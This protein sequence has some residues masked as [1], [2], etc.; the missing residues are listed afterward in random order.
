MAKRI[1]K[2]TITGRLGVNFIEQ[3]VLKMGFAWNPS[4]VDAGI[5]GYIE[6]RDQATDEAKNL[7]IAVQSKAT[8]KSL[9]GVRGNSFTFYCKDNDLTYWLQGNL[10][11]IF[12]Y[13]FT[14]TGEAFWIS[15]KEYFNT[16]A[17]R[18]SG[19]IEFDIKQDQFDKS[20]AESIKLLARPKGSGIYF[21]PPPLEET[22]W[23]NLLPVQ[24]PEHMYVASTEFRSRHAVREEL[25][26]KTG[27]Q[28]SDWLLRNKQIVS[29]H[30]LRADEWQSIADRGTAEIFQSSEWAASPDPSR[31]RE[32]VELL[33]YSLRERAFMEQ[34]EFNE[35]LDCYYFQLRKGATSRRF[36]FLGLKRETYHTVVAKLTYGEGEKARSYFRH[37]GFEPK[38]HYFAEQWFLEITPTYFFTEDGK[39]LYRFYED[40]L[41]GLKR[42]QRN[43]TVLMSVIMWGSL[44][45]S[46]QDMFSTRPVFLKFGRPIKF[47]FPVGIDDKAWLKSESE[48]ESKGI[49]DAIG[50]ASLFQ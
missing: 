26:K 49:T 50:E 12:V 22:L 11:V 27:Q 6:L 1:A 37:E 46:K 9:A 38:F 13:T 28:S 23:L 40:V 14:D 44:L 18:Q 4:T 15:I 35:F 20:C 19:K 36:S 10:P 30:D 34:L 5:D 45:Q 48:E 43:P 41:S 24:F 47:Q 33:N 32:F 16:S 8:S 21:N 25:K 17:K 31:K 39:R 29:F 2:Q 3:Q 7:V 42:L